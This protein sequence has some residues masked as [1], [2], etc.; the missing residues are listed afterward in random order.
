MLFFFFFFFFTKTLFSILPTSFQILY[1]KRMHIIH[2]N[3]AANVEPA[4]FLVLLHFLLHCWFNNCQFLCMRFGIICVF[5]II[6]PFPG[7]YVQV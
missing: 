6:S 4:D 1:V 5:Y 2:G 7:L 3:N